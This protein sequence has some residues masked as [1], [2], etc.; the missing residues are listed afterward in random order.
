MK[1]LRN[2]V[3]LMIV[4]GLAALL[5]GVAI[6]IDVAQ[7]DGFNGGALVAGLVGVGVF[8]KGFA[9]WTGWKSS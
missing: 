2:D 7:G 8:A 4:G 5:G 6:G 3:V 1:R 9:E